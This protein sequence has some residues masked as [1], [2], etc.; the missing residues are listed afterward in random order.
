MEFHVF[1]RKMFGTGL[2]TKVLDC[3]SHSRKNCNIFKQ[4]V[5]NIFYYI[6][7]QLIPRSHFNKGDPVRSLQSRSFTPAECETGVRVPMRNRRGLYLPEHLHA[8]GAERRAETRLVP[9]PRRGVPEGER[10]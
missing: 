5:T 4:L 10:K 8:P 1:E 2:D 3:F 9:H 7:I 6:H